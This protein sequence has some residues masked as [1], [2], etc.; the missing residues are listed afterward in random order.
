VLCINLIF[1]M[2]RVEANRACLLQAGI[3]RIK[4]MREAVGDTDDH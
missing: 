4:L 1:L 3:V 2:M